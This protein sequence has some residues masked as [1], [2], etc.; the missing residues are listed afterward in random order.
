MTETLETQ[1][2]ILRK[3]KASDLDAAMAFFASD[4][5][6]GVGGPLQDG[7]AW[8]GFAAEI[9]HWEIHGYGMWV[10]TRKGDDTALGMIG[11]WYPAG[12]PEKEIGWMIWDESVEGTGI[13]TEAAKAIIDHTWSVLKWDTIVNYIGPDNNRSIALAEK[14]GAKR[15]PNA[16]VPDGKDCFVYRH[17]K[18]EHLS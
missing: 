13:A 14:L 7:Q 11:P 16:A 15:D 3:P 8:R 1:R 10:V 2:L 6:V 18:P 9:G 17:T 4:R 5:S 12:W